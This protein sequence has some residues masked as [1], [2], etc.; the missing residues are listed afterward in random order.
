V[1][2]RG[3]AEAALEQASL[4]RCLSDQHPHE[5]ERGLYLMRRPVERLLPT[6]MT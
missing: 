4:W 6:K 2:M 3:L 1:A 5:D